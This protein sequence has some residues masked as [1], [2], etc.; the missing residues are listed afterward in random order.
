MV[1]FV[2]RRII[3]R[4]IMQSQ[5]Q[6]HGTNPNITIVLEDITGPV[7]KK[8]EKYS[9]TTI[10]GR[11]HTCTTVSVDGVATHLEAST[12]SYSDFGT[13]RQQMPTK[14]L[15]IMT[16]IKFNSTLLQVTLLASFASRTELAM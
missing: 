9:R 11:G 8:E 12:D 15:G 1:D 4:S 10:T 7:R 3:V 13:P 14:T 16:S 6:T 5:P 2:S